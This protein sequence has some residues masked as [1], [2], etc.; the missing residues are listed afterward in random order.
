MH[1][2]LKPLWVLPLL[3][4]VLTA[5]E[6]AVLPKQA[7]KTNGLVIHHE[8]PGTAERFSE[9][10]SKGVMYGRLRSNTFY[11]RWKE[12]DEKHAINLITALGASMVFDS[13]AY[14]GFDFGVGL[15]GSQAFFNEKDDPVARLKPGKDTLS[16]YDF[17]NTGTKAMGVIAQAWLRY[18]GIP[19]TQLTLGRQLV[20][21]FYTKSNDTKMIPNTFDGFVAKTAALPQ[22]ALTLGYLAEAKLRDHTQSHAVLMYGD[23]NST[24]HLY[25]Q[26]S[27]NDDSA[28]HRGLTY[29][30]LRAAGKPTHAPLIV[31]D[32]QNTSVDR[33]KISAAFYAVPDLLSQAMGELGYTFGLG[34]WTLVPGVRY[35]RQFDNGAGSVGGASYTTDTTGY[36]RPDSLD[37][38]MFGAR[39]IAKKG[40]YRFNLAYTQVA[41]EADLVT[42]WRG[43]PTSG[44]TRSMGIYNWRA[45]VR[46]YR[47]ELKVNDNAEAVYKDLFIQASILYIDADE[48]KESYHMQDE[49]YYYAGFIQ[50]VPSLPQLQWKLRL[51]Y[52]QFLHSEDERFSY[53][54]SRFELN[55]LF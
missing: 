23:A 12:E 4:S 54:D 47:L 55:Y 13:A 8:T 24:S 30:A 25:P 15:Y 49:L 10:F 43:F 35:I 27:E 36:T 7:L 46:S 39:L 26:W 6:S 51:G 45:N 11:F 38:Q 1:R 53:L 52:A 17:V 16:R 33:L 21:T 29:T 31:G 32:L 19:D 41:D 2:F 40:I 9:L 50:N 14:H 5:Q 3:A 20:E 42:P 22:T 48:K 28:M 18:G 34:G 37:S 44:Y